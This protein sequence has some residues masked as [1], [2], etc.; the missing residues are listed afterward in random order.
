VGSGNTRPYV[1]ATDITMVYSV[2]EIYGL[3]RISEQVLGNAAHALVGMMKTPARFGLQGKPAL[4]VSMSD[5]TAPCV[6]GVSE[7]LAASFECLVF[8]TTGVGGQS[9]EKLV[10]D[11]QLVGLL[12]ISTT[13]IANEIG[14]G[15][16]SSGT[17]RLD[18]VAQTGLP[19]VGSCGGLDMVSFHAMATVPERY[20]SRQLH[21]LSPHSTVMRTNETESRAI[22]AFI[23]DKLNHMHGPVRFFIPQGGV[24]ALDA[25]GHPF[26]NPEVD[27]ALFKAIQVN[28]VPAP[29]RKLVCVSHHINDAAFAVLL[30]A[31]WR[32]VTA[33][34]Q[35]TGTC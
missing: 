34:T 13:E 19:Y 21:A 6:H 31:A 3:N 9:M 30:A 16:L 1:G 23:A 28:F 35:R 20:R 32:E 27:Q 15:V 8:H 25:P 22:G 14:G 26:W 7:L 12:D 4:G 29:N 18:G 17:Q 5:T 33:G 11:G 2:T 10:T 24:S